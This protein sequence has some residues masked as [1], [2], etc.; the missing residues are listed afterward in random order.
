[1]KPVIGVIP[2]YDEQKESLWMLPG[3]FDG[4]IEQGG[5]PLM[6]PLVSDRRLLEQ[7]VSLCDGILFTGGHDVS[8]ELYR[9]E[10]LDTSLC[11]FCPERD[12]MERIV[13]ELAMEKDLPMLGICRGIQYIN[14]AL[15]GTLYQDLPTQHPSGVNHHQQAPYDLPVHEVQLP[16]G[17]P[18]H[19]AA[20]ALEG[21]T[22]HAGVT[23]PERSGDLYAGVNSCHHQAVRELAPALKVMAKAEDGIIEAVY[24]P[25]KRFLWAVQWHPEFS[26][27]NDP[28]SK[29]IFR[30]FVEAA[31]GSAADIL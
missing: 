6:L 8:P 15:G 14:V 18:L 10:V 12:A 4:L 3:Y 23:M 1:M 24:H 7:L 22:L 9:E 21:L 26:W 31:G 28:L 11:S 27:K 2:L 25:G 19:A 13:L 20:Q 17:T 29:T 16:E 30:A 5:V